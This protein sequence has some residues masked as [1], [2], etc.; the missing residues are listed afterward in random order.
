MSRVCQLCGRHT[1]VGNQVTRRGIAKK[2]GGIGRR[3]TGRNKR[4]FAPNLQYVRA[5]EGTR[6]VRKRIC[7]RCLKAGKIQKPAPQ[8]SKKAAS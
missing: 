1:Q 7:T 3:V 5:M 4:N 6:V 2:K 8:Q